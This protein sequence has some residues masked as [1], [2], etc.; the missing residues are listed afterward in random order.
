MSTTTRR[1]PRPA[2][3]PRN[4]RES[5]ACQGVDLNT[6][7]TENP[8]EQARIQRV[9]RTCPVRAICLT[10]ALNYEDSHWA[11]WGI[12]GGL[13]DWQRRA[14]RVEAELGNVPNLGQ[15]RKLVAPVFAS[16]MR[17]WR[18]WPAGTVAEELRRHGIIASPVTVRVALWWVGGRG[19][20]L[21]PKAEGDTRSPWMQVRDVCR[22]EWIR[23]RAAGFGNRDMVAYLGVSTDALEKAVTAW[24]ATEV[25][26]A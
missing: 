5:A 11:A 20:F 7:Y 14:L 16:F 17:Q 6:L 22:E 1:A 9:C 13:T 18:D 23:L 15:A 4:W 25:Q 12:A 10:D 21:P 3:F 26:A 19:S 8:T 2:A 24:R